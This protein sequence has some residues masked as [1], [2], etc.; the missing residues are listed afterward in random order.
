MKILEIFQIWI[1]RKYN[2]EKRSAGPLFNERDIFWCSIGSNIGHEMD[3]KWEKSNRPI[4]VIKKFNRHIFWWVPLSTQVKE[5]NLYYIPYTF[6]WKT[7]SAI[8]SQMRLMDSKRLIN[9]IGVLDESDF[10]K[11][12]E[13]IRD[14]L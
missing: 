13:K 11:I 2:L 6:D 3:G 12:K 5:N 7:A 9:R 8:I 1:Q 14:L 4:L 10:Y